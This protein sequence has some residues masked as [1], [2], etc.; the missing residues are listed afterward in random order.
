MANFNE[1]KTLGTIIR[2]ARVQTGRSLRE[3]AKQ[4]GITPSYESDI[5]NDR[6]VPAEEVLKKIADS[7]NL[8]FE[9]IMALAG[10]LGD[11]VE[12]YLRRQPA[13]GTLFRKLTETNASENLLRKMIETVENQNQEKGNL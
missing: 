3:F 6:R 5:E 8:K 13:A 12:R 7:L 2:D 11:D 9:E 4:L 1:V 10:R